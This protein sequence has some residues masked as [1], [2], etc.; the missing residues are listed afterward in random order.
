[1]LREAVATGTELGRQA[2]AVMERGDLVSDDIIIGLVRERLARDDCA[3]GFILDGFPRTA[4]QATA[5]DALLREQ[6]RAPARVVSLC[7][8][9]EE[10]T[11]RILSRGE[12]RADDTEEAV[13]NRLAVYERETA[14]VLGHYAAAVTEVDGLG[15]VDEISDRIAKE[16]EGA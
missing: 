3:A 14:P 2:R 5:L 10:L 8:P 1:M 7:V 13:R 9:D 11:R 6:G 16:L 15:S 12:G 4:A